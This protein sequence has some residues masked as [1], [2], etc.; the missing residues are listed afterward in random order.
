M[1]LFFYRK[2]EIFINNYDNV[3]FEMSHIVTVHIFHPLPLCIPS[4][5]I[6]YIPFRNPTSAL[7]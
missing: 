3:E 2:L 6:V 7:L 4:H 1:I 5:C